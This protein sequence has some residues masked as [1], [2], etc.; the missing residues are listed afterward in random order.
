MLVSIDLDESTEDEIVAV[1]DVAG[2]LIRIKSRPSEARGKG[3]EDDDAVAAGSGDG[4]GGGGGEGHQQPMQGP[5]QAKYANVGL[6]LWQAGLV[7]ADWIIRHCCSPHQ[8]PAAASLTGMEGRR[9][10]AGVSVVELG[11]GVGQCSIALSAAGAGPVVMT[12]LPHIVPLAAENARLN[13]GATGGRGGLVAVPYVWGE[14]AGPVLAALRQKDGDDD[15]DDRRWPDLLVAADCLYEP[16]VY[17]LLISA[18]QRL[19]GPNTR[20]VLCHR[21]RV[22]DE[23]GFEGAAQE[24]GFEVRAAPREQLHPDYACGGWRLVV[25]ER[26]RGGDDG[27]DG[28]DEEKGSRGGGEAGAGAG[29]AAGTAAAGDLLLCDT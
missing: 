5:T 26:R 16:S 8:Q 11:C 23:R 21:L 13:A 20:V 14:D 15:D 3:E 22:Y 27:E 12:D 6:V 1:Y 25:G 17:P 19:S 28:D 10:L 9:R 18:I 29:A 24:A 4:G 7:A 2:A